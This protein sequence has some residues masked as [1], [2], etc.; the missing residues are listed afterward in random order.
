[1]Y[2]VIVAFFPLHQSVCATA[3]LAGAGFM[4]TEMEDSVQNVVGCG[5]LSMCFVYREY[6][7]CV[8]ALSTSTLKKTDACNQLFCRPHISEMGC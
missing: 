8:T 3:N 4:Q 6:S 1:M 2:V 5:N 7:L